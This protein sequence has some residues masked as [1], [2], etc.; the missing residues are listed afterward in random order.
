MLLNHAALSL[1]C[2]RT[3]V[4]DLLTYELKTVID[5]N[6][7]RECSS[8]IAKTDFRVTE[9]QSS[10]KQSKTICLLQH[11]ADQ[12]DAMV[13]EGSWQLLSALVLIASRAW[14]LLLIGRLLLRDPGLIVDWNVSESA[15][16]IAA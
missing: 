3:E 8:K 2:K 12:R 14:P 10:A 6:N 16:T 1:L 9:Y 4:K 7:V 15:I 5:K 13:D 11:T